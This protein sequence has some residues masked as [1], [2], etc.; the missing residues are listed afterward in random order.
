MDWK[1]IPIPVLSNAMEEASG[2]VAVHNTIGTLLQLSP[3]IERFAS[4]VRSNRR[5]V[6]DRYVESDDKTLESPVPTFID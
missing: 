1:L 4:M 6:S 2:S 5:V 3:D